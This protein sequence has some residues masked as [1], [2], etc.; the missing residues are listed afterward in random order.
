MTIK[1]ATPSTSGSLVFEDTPTAGTSALRWSITPQ[2]NGGQGAGFS[3]LVLAS[4]TSAAAGQDGLA[5]QAYVRSKGSASGVAN[6]EVV[7]DSVG[8]QGA[9]NQKERA[10]ACRPGGAPGALFWWKAWVHAHIGACVRGRGLQVW[11]CA[12]HGPPDL[13]LSAGKAGRSLDC[14][15]WMVNPCVPQPGRQALR[16]LCCCVF[17]C[18]DRI[19]NCGCGRRPHPELYR[20]C[21]GCR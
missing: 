21:H 8:G 6:G 15:S 4:D 18:A 16:H 5:V 13:P 20:H 9:G 11:A 1:G 10:Q 14:L 2:G 7:A 3:T 19:S 17:P 12:C